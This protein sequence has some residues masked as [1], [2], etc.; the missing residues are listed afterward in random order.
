MP[1]PTSLQELDRNRLTRMSYLGEGAFGEVD[2][3]QV[4]E[5]RQRGVP[6]YK[7]FH[8]RW[9]WWWRGPAVQYG[10]LDSPTYAPTHSHTHT[11][12]RPLTHSLTHPQP[13]P[14]LSTSFA[15]DGV[16]V[17]AKTVKPGAS[18]GRDEL[19]KEAALM[20]LMEHRNVLALVGVSGFVVVCGWWCWRSSG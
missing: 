2:L 9:W 4:D 7:V 15:S 17:A 3:Y 6:P 8:A 5:S 12:N 13:T 10:G 18:A 20:A 1:I 19:L 11:L 14:S 16:Q